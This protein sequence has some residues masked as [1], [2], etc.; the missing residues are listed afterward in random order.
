MLEV[1]VADGVKLTLQDAEPVA[2]GD[3]V[4]LL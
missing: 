3:R 1:P 2:T 4:Q